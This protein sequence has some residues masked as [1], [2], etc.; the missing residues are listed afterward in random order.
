MEMNEL[1]HLWQRWLDLNDTPITG[2]DTFTEAGRK[3]ISTQHL[4]LDL[5]EFQLKAMTPK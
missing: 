1:D 4:M 5:I 2:R 3:L